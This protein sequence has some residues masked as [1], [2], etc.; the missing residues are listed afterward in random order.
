MAQ[1]IQVTNKESGL[2]IHVEV[3]H[4]DSC[5][6]C[7]RSITPSFVQG[8]VDGKLYEAQLIYYCPSDKCHKIFIAYGDVIGN[9]RRVYI[10]RSAPIT[11]KDPEFHEVILTISP[12]FVE[13][14]KQANAAE[15]QGLDKI[16]GPG[17]RKALEF[18][19]K[20]YLLGRLQ[21]PDSEDEAIL[22]AYNVEI[23]KIKTMQ[24]GS[25][26]KD[27]INNERIKE[28]SKRAAWLGNDQVHYQIKWEE[29]DISDLK[30]TIDL[31]VNWIIHEN[32]T[33]QVLADMPEGVEV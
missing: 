14:F 25:C 1:T 13:I 17:Y 29:K 23:N 6:Q 11:H 3:E 20:D 12:S 8:F 22:T 5:P 10:K 15:S 27:K 28:I 30:K 32:L 7:H 9:R 24:L 21:K 18:L 4:P 2:A 16:S 33:E 31:T 19:V 26:I